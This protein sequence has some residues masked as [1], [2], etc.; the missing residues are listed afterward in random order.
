MLEKDSEVQKSEDLLLYYKS[1]DREMWVKHFIEDREFRLGE[2]FS[3]EVKNSYER[4]GL[5]AASVN[6]TL[7][8]TEQIVADLTANNPRFDAV[9]IEDSDVKIA[10]YVSRLFDWIYYVSKGQTKIEFFARDFSNGG[11]GWLLTYPDYNADYG[12]GELKVKDVDPLDVYVD[13]ACKEPDGSDSG[14]ILIA[15]ILSEEVINNTYD[16]DLTDAEAENTQDY[17]RQRAETQGQV[18]F[19]A[20]L[21]NIKHYRVI[22]RFTKIKITRYHVYDPNTGYENV[23]ETKEDYD[24]WAQSPAII[25]TE[26]NGE[27][28]I[29]DDLEVQKYI[30]ILETI[31][32]TFHVMDDGMGN[33]ELMAGYE[34]DSPYVIKNSTTQIKEVTK[35]DFVEQGIILKDE[36]KIDRIRRVLSIGGKLIEN[37]VLPISNYPIVASMLDHNRN[38]YPTG[39]IRRVK[40]LQ[41]QLNVLDS[42]I[43]AYLRAIST[44]R[45]FTTQ[46]SGVKKLFDDSGDPLGI[47]IYEVNADDVSGAVVFPQ[48]PQLPAGIFAQR[49]N[50]IRQIQRIIGAYSFQDGEA[51]S[52]PRTASGTAQID[53]FMRRRSAYKKRKLEASIEQLGKVMAE[54]VPYIYTERKVLRV[55][56]PNHKS[57]IVINDPIE[58]NGEVKLLNNVTNVRLDVRIIGDSTLPTNRT[59]ESE[60]LLRAYELRML[61]NPK[62]WIKKQNFED[63]EEVLVEEDLIPQLES[64]I[65]QLQEEV[66]GL[67]GQLQSKTRENISANEKVEIEKTKSNLKSLESETKH[68]VLH[69]KER[70]KDLE[71]IEKEKKNGTEHPARASSR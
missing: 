25:I 18:I 66:K 3:E 67:Q 6:E 4:K 61:R 8:A 7:P 71:K 34:H 43:Q 42:R 13:P 12:K 29:T 53:E 40:P 65:Q 59:L 19:S 21:A 35:G 46:G 10:S 11:L 48:Y 32:D 17:A 38:P 36:P 37:E 9:A 52:S 69:T 63:M 62:W 49:E 23:F 20:K 57:P 68:A 24:K 70:L 56:Q 31:G 64:A 44:L 2:Q 28:Y 26:L 5:M 15:P 55:T 1:G 51:V 47:E 39:D 27:S 50:I 60:I 30:E 45:A 54:Y 33:R 58:E 14:N 16:I 22:E 41:E